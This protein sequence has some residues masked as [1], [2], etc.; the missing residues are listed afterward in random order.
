[1][2]LTFGLV[3]MLTILIIGTGILVFV[4]S[5]EPQGSF[6]PIVS[7]ILLS[8]GFYILIRFLLEHIPM[9]YLKELYIIIEW[10]TYGA[11]DRKIGNKK[12]R[13]KTGVRPK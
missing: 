11:Y 3:G 6:L 5:F 1:M 12:I 7:A 2:E 4:D 10:M 13:M 8:F 9:V